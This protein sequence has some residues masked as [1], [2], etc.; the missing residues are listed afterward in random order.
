[1][2]QTI[3]PREISPATARLADCV[4]R[5]RAIYSMAEGHKVYRAVPSATIGS[6]PSLSFFTCAE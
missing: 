4:I 2:S 1:M 6:S 3:S 5:A